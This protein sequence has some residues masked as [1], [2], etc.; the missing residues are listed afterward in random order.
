MS[1]LAKVADEALLKGLRAM[2]PQSHE[3]MNKSRGTVLAVREGGPYYYTFFSEKWA[4]GAK[5]KMMLGS[6]K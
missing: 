4:W 2:R 3:L 6:Q 1:K 5:N